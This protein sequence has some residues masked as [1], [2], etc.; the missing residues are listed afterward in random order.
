M[1][2]DSTFFVNEFVLR[3][4]LS[5]FLGFSSELELEDEDEEFEEELEEE[6]DVE[7][8]ED[9]LEELEGESLKSSFFLAL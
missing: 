9:E 2:K 6:E 4:F 8:E 1:S 7:E 3:F 5:D